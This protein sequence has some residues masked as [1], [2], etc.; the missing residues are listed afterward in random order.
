MKRMS[1]VLLMALV[2]GSTTLLALVAEP[3]SEEQNTPVSISVTQEET[4]SEGILY[5]REEEKLA[6]DVYLSLYETWGIKTFANIAR[7]EQ[8][9]M[10]AV[11]SLIQ[12]QGLVD[13]VAG[14]VVGEFKNPDLAALYDQLIAKG[15]VSPQQALAVGALI[16][17]LDIHDLENYL[18]KTDDS[19]SIVVYTNLLKGSEN[20]M[21]SFIRQLDRYNLTYEP[22]YISQERLNG[23][24]AR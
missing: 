23:I 14:S 20:H 24:L 6:R 18:S 5:M 13:P 10:D 17:D 11:A 4:G 2:L 8:T 21:R 16:E 19:A 1:K 22:E 9:H 3:I 7:S 15:T 12:A